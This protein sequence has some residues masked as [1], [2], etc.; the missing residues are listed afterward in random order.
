MRR[1]PGPIRSAWP[2]LLCLYV[3]AAAVNTVG[4]GWGLPGQGR[5]LLP[6]VPSEASRVADRSWRTVQDPGRN[7][8]LGP[9][10][11]DQAETPAKTLRRF[12]LYT[13]DPDEQR[14]VM[15]VARLNP[16]A[17][18]WDP[19]IV[20][21]GGLFVYAVAAAYKLAS[22]FD[23]ILLRSDPS[24]YLTNPEAMARIYLVG[25]LAVVA[26]GS[27]AIPVV[28]LLARPW[29]SPGT[30]LLASLVAA[31]SPA[32]LAW[33]HILKPWAFGAPFALL[34]LAMGRRLLGTPRPARDAVGAGLA[35]GLA[36]SVAVTNAAV[37]LGPW[38]GIALRRGETRGRRLAWS[39][40]VAG[41]AAVVAGVLQW[42]WL[43]AP[44]ETIA[45]WRAA[46]GWFSPEYHPATLAAFAWGALGPALGPPLALAGGIEGALQAWRRRDALPIMVPVALMFCLVAV[47]AG[48]NAGDGLQARAVLPGILVLAMS[49]VGGLSRAGRALPAAV[50]SLPA[51]LV[52]PSLLVAGAI[53]RNFVAASGPEGTRQRGGAWLNTLPEGTSL[54]VLAPLAP[55]R[56]PLFRFDRYR[57][58]I[59]PQP[60]RAEGGPDHFLV[61]ERSEVP[62]APGF[63]A[64]YQEVRRFAPP[65]LP[66]GE[67]ARAVY[68]FADPPVIV[69]A[70][71]GP[72][73]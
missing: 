68:P 20:Q 13:A 38:L 70:R 15:A 62:T 37:L 59:D 63:L 30:A 12:F 40:L 45:A 43:L 17:G 44:G 71:L 31:L 49:G 1:A 53:L 25:R 48:S 67:S 32:W 22:M 6:A 35:A 56:S 19:G 23:I 73:Q 5:G 66:L 54:G 36:A 46:S 18:R 64:R 58:V 16:F 47:K 2:V 11:P 50:R 21:Y 72:H 60:E 26:V 3:F 65:A 55:F 34:A 52:I 9:P 57:L 10:D 29:Y 8:D 61:A 42:Y 28:W 27:A 33:S 51:V 24:F 7:L 4:I 69:Y 39:A 14:S 41:S